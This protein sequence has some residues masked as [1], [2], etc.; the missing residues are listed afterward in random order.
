MDLT[1]RQSQEG[2]R[3]DGLM[4]VDG[5]MHA[6]FETR[7]YCPF[8]AIAYSDGCLVS[9]ACMSARNILLQRQ[10]MRERDNGP[11]QARTGI[12][13]IHWFQSATVTLK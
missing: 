4:N 10:N 2:P 3:D 5:Q 6:D 12:L 7:P 9:K 13:G 8:I 11:W 1:L